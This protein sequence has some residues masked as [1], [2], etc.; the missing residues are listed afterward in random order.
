MKLKFVVINKK[1]KNTCGQTIECSL[2]ANRSIIAYHNISIYLS[3]LTLIFLTYIKFTF[4]YLRIFLPKLISY[5]YN[6]MG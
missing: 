6:F 3:C 5:C 4:A 1:D 2:R